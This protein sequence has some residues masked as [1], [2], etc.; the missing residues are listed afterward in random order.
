M[1]EVNRKRM[2]S[3][4]HSLGSRLVSPARAARRNGR[5]AERPRTTASCEVENGTKTGWN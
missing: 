3:P 4:T 5:S 1:V 2:Q